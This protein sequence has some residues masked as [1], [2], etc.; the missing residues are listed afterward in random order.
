MANTSRVEVGRGATE[1]LGIAEKLVA[2]HNL[3]GEGSP[4]NALV[5]INW[6][7]ITGSVPKALAK[8]R[9]AEELRA[10]ADAAYRERDNLLQPIDEMVR[11]S[12]SLLKAVHVKNPKLLTEWGFEVTYTTPSK[13]KPEKDEKEQ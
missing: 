9:E 8:H 2:K 10:K 7:L 4:L 1:I 12:R 5:D 11:R 6:P 3:D 13:T